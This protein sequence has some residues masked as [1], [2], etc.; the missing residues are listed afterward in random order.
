MAQDRYLL[1]VGT[2]KPNKNLEVLIR[3]FDRAMKNLAD[4]CQL[5]IVAMPDPRYQSAPRLVRC[6]GLEESV[7]F[8]DYVIESDLPAIYSGASMLVLPSLHEGFGFPI[9][10]AMACGAPVITS[11]VAAMPEVAG[12]AALLVDPRSEVRLSEAIS[13]LF[14]DRCLAD[15]LKE[16]GFKRASQFSW[17]A[18]AR[19]LVQV[20]HCC[21]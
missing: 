8:V 16:R 12:D 2:R 14:N 18:A 9:L 1:Y 7:N 10:E 19:Q 20:Y 17:L 21:G 15:N 11:S 6:L 4:P 13:R 3:G 5:V